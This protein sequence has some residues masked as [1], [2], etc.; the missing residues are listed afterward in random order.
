MTHGIGSVTDI[1]DLTCD[2][3]SSMIT[4]FLAY[5]TACDLEQSFSSVMTCKNY[6]QCMIS[7]SSTSARM[8][9]DDAG[10]VCVD[11]CTGNET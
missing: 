9:E 10:V 1:P 5:I 4:T 2:L 8:Y 3:Y 7:S 6:S 11:M